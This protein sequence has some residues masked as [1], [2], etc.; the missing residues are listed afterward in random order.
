MKL[1]AEAKSIIK[2]AG[3]SQAAWARR[4]FNTNTW[5]GDAC[6]CPDDRCMDG[7]HHH[8][9][10]ACGCLAYLITAPAPVFLEVAS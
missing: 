7:Y 1:N 4:H 3:F 2:D 6:G 8:P 10:E 9:H 5:F